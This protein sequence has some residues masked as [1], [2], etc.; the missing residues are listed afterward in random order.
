GIIVANGL[1]ASGLTMG[2]YIGSQLAN[3]AL[4]REIDIDLEKYN[5]KGAL[6]M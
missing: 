5:V 3:L 4:D 1:G 2:P 6:G